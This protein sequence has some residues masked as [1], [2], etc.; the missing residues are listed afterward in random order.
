MLSYMTMHC[1]LQTDLWLRFD[2]GVALIALYNYIQCLL[3][4]TNDQVEVI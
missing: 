2:M 1:Y 4:V 3:G